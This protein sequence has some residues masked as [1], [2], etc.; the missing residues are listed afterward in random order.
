MRD[1]EMVFHSVQS[2][3]ELKYKL[4]SYKY[5]GEN[6]KRGLDIEDMHSNTMGDGCDWSRTN[7]LSKKF[8]EMG[9][10]VAKDEEGKIYLCQ[11]FRK[12]RRRSPR[13]ASSLTPASA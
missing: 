12:G 4:S 1:S 8:T 5:V 7:I 3:V 11:L 10:A 2:L 13:E 9:C 6:V